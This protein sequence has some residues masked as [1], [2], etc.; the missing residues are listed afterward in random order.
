MA[1]FRS[2]YLLPAFL[3]SVAL[4]AS[5]A[6]AG[7]D[8]SFGPSNGL[9]SGPISFVEGQAGKLH[10]FIQR[11][12]VVTT[13]ALDSFTVQF[14]LTSVE[15]PANGLLFT[16]P[17]QQSQLV[18]ANYV[19]SG[20]SVVANS[21][22]AQTIGSVQNSGL[23]Y[24]GSDTVFA[25]AVAVPTSNRLLFS[26]DLNPVAEGNYLISVA[27]A[28]SFISLDPNFNPISVPF[29]SSTGSIRVNAVPE[30]SALALLTS[31]L[32]GCLLTKRRRRALEKSR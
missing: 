16:N 12:A 31:C 27:A 22:G 6:E 10:V 25:A 24:T 1:R 28:S 5:E 18:S 29:T 2:L 23:R 19:F 11:D 21:N 26:L 14:N 17:Q 3:L 32:P 30:P 9:T 13:P 7:F 4:G 20:N 15:S 8:I